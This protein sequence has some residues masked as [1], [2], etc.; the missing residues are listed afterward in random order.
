M[1]V[2]FDPGT[3]P[4]AVSRAAELA[5]SL[6]AG[7]YEVSWAGRTLAVVTSYPPEA[8]SRFERS[9]GV[10]RVICPP[11]LAQ[12][13]SRAV[14]AAGT[15]V[16]VSGVAIGDG[17][18]TVAAGPCAVESAAQLR[19]TA[20]A[21]RRERAALLRGGAVKP[22]TSPYSFQGLGL[23]ALKLLA[24]ER[25]RTGLRVVTEVMEP[26]QVV[27][28]AAH[29]D[30]LQVGS[31]NMQNFSL[32]KELG[33]AERPV[34]L[35]RGM[36]ATIEEWLLAAEHVMAAGNADVVMCERGIRTFGSTARFTLDLGVIPLLKRLSHLPVLVDPS[37]AL[38][39]GYAVPPMMLAAAAAGADGIL[40]DVHENPGSARCDGD[41][42]MRP[43]VFR[44]A[45]ADVS[46]VL[47]SLGRELVEPLAPCP[48]AGLAPSG[49]GQ[50]PAHTDAA[51]RRSAIKAQSRDNSG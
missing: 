37:H 48:A 35:K 50:D 47:E 51:H 39:V 9:P 34:L 49:P 22:R 24:A 20:D 3:R 45:M 38:G 14:R 29:A 30:M 4:G 40:V 42:A 7:F 15:V 43:D 2:E 26:G 41:Q 13:S 25:R 8:R 21:V 36:G 6:S 23:A 17:R 28:V 11:G 32:L 31:R 16:D 33:R 44:A 19:V 18:F 5:A 12:L 10:S 46:R 27:T 1:I